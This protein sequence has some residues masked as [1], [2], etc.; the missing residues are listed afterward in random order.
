MIVKVLEALPREDDD[1]KLRVGGIYLVQER[2]GIPHIS[3]RGVTVGHVGWV[4][5]RTA[6]ARHSFECRGLV[7][8]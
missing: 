7:L 5:F 4:K 6:E 1:R 2:N 8:K 3:P